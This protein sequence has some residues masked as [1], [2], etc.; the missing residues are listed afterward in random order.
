MSEESAREYEMG[1][2]IKQL[3]AELEDYT[4]YNKL[5][6]KNHCLQQ[7]IDELKAKNKLILKRLDWTVA[8]NAKFAMQN[9]DL[10]LKVKEL[11]AIA[12]NPL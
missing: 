6:H 4:E 10:E 7:H 9:S 8:C 2:R 11:E 1:K 5:N 3:E 12:Y